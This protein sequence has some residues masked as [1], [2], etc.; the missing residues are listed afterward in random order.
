M[1]VSVVVGLSNLMSNMDDI[2]RQQIPFALAKA[3]TAT[4]KQVQAAEN[5][6]VARSF[7]RPT[8]FTKKAFAI[9]PAT[10]HELVARVFAKDVQNEYLLP[11]V[12]GGT[13]GFKTFEEKFASGSDAKVALP[14][15]AV[16]LNQYGNMS[17]AKILQIARDLNSSGNAKRFFKGVPKGSDLPDG[18]YARVNNN[19]SIAPLMVFATEAVYKKR[20]DFSAIAKEEVTARFEQNMAAAW[21]QAIR[22]ARR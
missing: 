9:S 13:R 6:G 3:L 7:D 21:S 17:K 1:S 19:T 16:K 10:K 14:G 8:P 2:S 5:A 12:E 15:A 22:T 11:Q 18:I 4:A 20:F